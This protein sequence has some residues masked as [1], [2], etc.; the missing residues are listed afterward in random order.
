MRENGF[1]IELRR[2]I[3]KYL[4]AGHSYKTIAKDFGISVYSEKYIRD[5]YR[6]GDLS[7]FDGV[8]TCTR[9]EDSEKLALVNAFLASGLT[10]ATFA[11]S[12]GINYATFRNWVRK[13][14]EGTLKK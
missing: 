7:Y 1:D 3:L 11:K 6:R 12:E 14:Q 5:I 10:L 4:E 2:S 8:E 13:H 9:R